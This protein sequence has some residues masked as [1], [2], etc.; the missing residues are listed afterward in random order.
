VS[1]DAGSLGKLLALLGTLAVALFATWLLTRHERRK[2]PRALI[3]GYPLA[4]F[5]RR[6]SLAGAL[7]SLCRTQSTLLSLY[8]QLPTS[9]I[10]RPR[11]FAFL[12]EL[13]CVMDG[14]YE[15]ALR[16]TA[17]DGERLARLSLDAQSAA[18]EMTKS[19]QRLLAEPSESSLDVE[20]DVRMEIMRTLARDVDEL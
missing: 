14:A 1:A 17:L 12:E 19:T 2:P 3:E 4:E 16:P 13:R 8:R 15:L 10:A 9:S 11:L 5:P 7:A 18:E 20:L 6:Q